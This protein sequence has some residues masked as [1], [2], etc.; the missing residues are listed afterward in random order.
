MKHTILVVDDEHSIRRSVSAILAE[1]GYEVKD[2]ASGR[3]ALEILKNEIIHA[4]LLDIWMPEMDGLETLKRIQVLSPETLVIMMSGHGT[5]E[6]AVKATKLGAFDFLEKPPSLEK[7]LV[8]LQNGLHAY[9]LKK[10]NDSLRKQIRSSHRMV[11]DSPAMASIHELIQRVAPTTGSVLITGENGTGKEMIAHLIH[12]LSPRFGKQMVAVN[13]A[14]IPE[15]LIESELFGHERGAFTGANQMRRGKF[16]LADGG[17]IFLDEIGDMSLRTQ[18]KVLRILQ[19]Q[20]FERVGGNQTYSVDVRIV[21]ATNKDLKQEIA[22]GLFRE[23]LFYRLNVIPF[24]LPPLRDRK[25][26]IAPLCQHFIE[27]FSVSHGRVIRKLE[28]D[29]VAVLKEYLWPG[30]V[31]ELKNLMERLVILSSPTE[32]GPYI[33]VDEVV[34]NIGADLIAKES[35]QG[36]SSAGVPQVVKDL[37]ENTRTQVGR[38]LREARSDFERDFILE[39][40]RSAEWNVSKAAQILGIERSHLHKKIKSYGIENDKLDG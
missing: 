6:T 7:L 19:E 40:L 24:H 28:Q 29:T 26:D 38:N 8:V 27:D 36:L 25:E 14:A 34:K 16:D 4:I 21:A 30:N 15:E 31:R 35:D 20:K 9:Q 39:T 13:C 37:K 23:D 2:A 11:G 3:A 5:I 22:K 17:T 18:A 12:S 10:D 1:E 33:S 32:S